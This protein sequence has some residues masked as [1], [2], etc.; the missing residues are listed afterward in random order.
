VLQE[1]PA[2]V[3]DYGDIRGPAALRE[4][5]ARYLARSRGVLADPER[6]VVCGGFN[7][8]LTALARV[9]HERGDRELAFED[10]SLP[11][12]R[13]TAAA[14]GPRISAVP[15]DEHGLRVSELDSPAV[16]VTPAH[17]YPLGYTLAPARR[18]ALARWH[19]G[20]AEPAA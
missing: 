7:R 3:F 16:V 20:R 13:A 12:F 15:V 8:L 4:A 6:I 9:L 2:Q 10:P 14:A 17:Q 1:A 5:L 11:Q 19:A 18:S